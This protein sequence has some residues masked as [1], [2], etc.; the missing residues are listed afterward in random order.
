[1]VEAA[2]RRYAGHRG[3]PAGAH[4]RVAAARYLAAH[5]PTIRAQD[6]TL[7][8]ALRLQRGERL[9]EDTVA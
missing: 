1:M 3:T 9:Y 4:V 7:Q 2:F 6:Q 8:I 5:A